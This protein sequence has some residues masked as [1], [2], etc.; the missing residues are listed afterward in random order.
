MDL[1][2]VGPRE[3]GEMDER[4]RKMICM[5]VAMGEPIEA[6]ARKVEVEEKVVHAIIGSDDGMDQILRFQMAMFPDPMV[7]VK[8]M[9]NLA[10]DT[11]MKLMT[12]AGTS[13]SVLAKVT[14]DVLD[15]AMGKA[16]QVVENR[17]LNVN[18]TDMQS[19]DRALKA[20]Q[21]RLARLE[22]VQQKLLEARD[23]KKK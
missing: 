8:R 19:A 15:R 5:L 22:A 17:N 12:R 7:R 23:Q 4:D 11:Q 9:A 10:L 6:V 1:L 18:V 14:Q 16:T 3:G 13:D 20:Q 21:E 2:G